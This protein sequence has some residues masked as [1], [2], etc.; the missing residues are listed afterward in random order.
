MTRSFTLATL[1][2]ILGS[3]TALAQPVRFSEIDRNRDGLLSYRELENTFGS[4]GADEVWSRGDGSPLSARD[5]R[6][7][8]SRDDDDD[9]RGGWGGRA[10][11]DD[12][13]DDDRRGGGW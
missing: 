13:D 11:R 10:D 9:S 1:A 6:S 2:L 12:D 7:A 5:I 4:R 3:T 8:A